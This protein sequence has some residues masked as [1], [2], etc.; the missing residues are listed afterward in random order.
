MRNVPT[1]E[2]NR[3]NTMRAVGFVPGDMATVMS[4]SYGAV[5]YWHTSR[6][7]N[8]RKFAVIKKDKL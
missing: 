3:K 2:Q 6:H 8:I 4:K 7:T 1:A 5:V